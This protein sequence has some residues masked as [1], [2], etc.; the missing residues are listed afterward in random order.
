MIDHPYRIVICPRCGDEVAEYEFDEG[1][2]QMH[3]KK[4]D[5]SGLGNPPY[6]DRE[7]GC[8]VLRMLKKGDGW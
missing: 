2:G 5:G 6:C 3:L 8:W 1:T 4:D 7:L